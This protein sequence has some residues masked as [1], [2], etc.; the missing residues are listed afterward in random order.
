MFSRLYS[1]TL[2]SEQL[3][4]PVL[5]YNRTRPRSRNTHT[6]THSH[7]NETSSP[8][9][10]LTCSS[11]QS[12]S[13]LPSSRSCVSSK[14]VPTRA[15]GTRYSKDVQH[16]TSNA[17]HE[18]QTYFTVECCGLWH[19]PSI[20]LGQRPKRCIIQQHVILTPIASCVSSRGTGNRPRTRMVRTNPG[21]WR[22]RSDLMFPGLREV[23][24][25]PWSPYR[26]A[27]SNAITTLPCHEPCSRHVVSIAKEAASGRTNLLWQ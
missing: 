7:P 9:T 5:P 14:G 17:R 26:R 15:Q 11:S 21:R 27:S 12:K 25:I 10:S 24:T 3:H 19:R 8:H 23:D 16:P 4:R 20:Q 6:R 13:F 1:I 2:Y 18:Q 22:W